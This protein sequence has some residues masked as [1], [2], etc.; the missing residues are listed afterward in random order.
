MKIV[1]PD[2]E[3]FSEAIT[4]SLHNESSS[5][6]RETRLTRRKFI[7]LACSGAG[8]ALSF[9]VPGVSKEDTADAFNLLGALVV[10]ISLA[11]GLFQLYENVKGAFGLQNDSGRSQ[12]GYVVVEVIDN[13]TR[14]KEVSDRIPVKAPPGRSSLSFSCSGCP[15]TGPKTIVMYTGHNKVYGHFLVN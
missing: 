7:Y 4:T 6:S 15:T 13:R 14:R 11:N 12:E 3:L 9:I 10:G 1:K 8:F 5:L 2:S